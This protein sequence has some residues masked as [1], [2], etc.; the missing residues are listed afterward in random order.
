MLQRG[1]IGTYTESNY[2]DG[3]TGDGVYAF[4]FDTEDASLELGQVTAATNPSFLVCDGA[5][6]LAVNEVPDGAVS[7]FAVGN[8]LEL[9]GRASSGGATPCHLALAGDVA[10]VANYGDGAIAKLE[11]GADGGLTLVQPVLKPEATGPHP[12]RQR[13]P[14]GHGIYVQPEQL[15]TVDLGGD[16]IYRYEYTPWGELHAVLELPP[17]SGP[18]HAAFAEDRVYVIS[19]LDNSVLELSSNRRV[20]LAGSDQRGAS[21]G[22]IVAHHGH[23]YAS[24]RGADTLQ[25][26][27][28]DL[29]PLQVLPSGGLHPRHMVFDPS[30]RYLLVG[31]MHSDAVAVFACDHMTRLLDGPVSVLPVPS[32]ACIC[33]R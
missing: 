25:V 32:P 11:L 5:T 33:W 20:L 22:E 7:R 10:Y 15:W 18:R 24:L 12:R 30:G 28:Q 26:F 14:H 13:S 19:E 9:T 23:V 1:Y 2:S 16:R 6:L 27:D 21:A 8:D 17:G 4:T 31:N 29:R 3:R